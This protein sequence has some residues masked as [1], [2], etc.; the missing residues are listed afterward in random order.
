M[1][2]PIVNIIA[3]QS[4]TEVTEVNV[5]QSEINSLLAKYGYV[6]N[7]YVEQN[8]CPSSQMTFEEMVQAEELRL[9]QERLNRRRP[10][11]IT[12]DPHSVRYHQ[13]E[14]GSD[15]D[16]GFGYQITIASDMDI[17]K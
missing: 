13:T 7:H 17:K 12:I 9:K 8:T 16:Y 11:T 14:Y 6:E 3:H 10:N 2:K 1:E 4:E 15:S 5:P